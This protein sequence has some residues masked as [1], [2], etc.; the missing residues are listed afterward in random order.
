M[1][2]V[3]WGCLAKPSS[4][5]RQHVLKKQGGRKERE[6]VLQYYSVMYS[7]TGMVQTA[8]TARTAQADWDCPVQCDA[9]YYS[10]M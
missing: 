3:A 8:Q 2:Q 4:T 9:V 10:V 6:I 7:T 1:K 5:R